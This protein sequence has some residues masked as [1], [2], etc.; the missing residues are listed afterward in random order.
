M[1]ANSKLETR[2]LA[3][4]YAGGI[5]ALPEAAVIHVGYEFSNEIVL[6]TPSIKGNR[7]ELTVAADT[8]QLHVLEGSIDVLGQTLGEGATMLL[9]HYTP[10][11]IGDEYIAFGYSEATE[12]SRT[13]ALELTSP[14]RADA[15]PDPAAHANQKRPW[16]SWLLGNSSDRNPILDRPVIAGIM[17]MTVILFFGLK[18]VSIAGL[19]S[20]HQDIEQVKAQLAQFGAKD[21]RVEKIGRTINISGFV[22]SKAQANTISDH[23]AYKLQSVKLQLTTGVEMA[24]AVG[25]VLRI[26]GVSGETRYIGSR[27]VEVATVALEPSQMEALE[28]N[29]RHDVPNLRELR[30]R[31]TI[32]TAF[33]GINGLATA[34]AN[35]GKRISSLVAGETGYLVTADGGHYFVGS[36]L[37]TGHQII[38]IEGRLVMLEQNGT[39]V[40]WVF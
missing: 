36:V 11:R 32:G 2:I 26:Q 17:A 1:T 34:T 28:K 3:G 9:P 22:D 14:A 7:T 27:S 12:W 19:I 21:L 31:N 24:Q 23:F 10:M 39:P 18:G 30:F 5:V 16:S 35:P 29:V 37:P 8:V 15:R 38:S 40:R 6:R 4:R 25:D 20:P 13:L 33:N